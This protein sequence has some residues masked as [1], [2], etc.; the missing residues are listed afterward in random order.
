[1]ALNMP[2]SLLSNRQ[3]CA[4]ETERV[5]NLVKVEPHL[6]KAGAGATPK[7]SEAEVKGRILGLGVWM[8]NNGRPESSAKSTMNILKMLTKHTANF[9]DP[10]S[11]KAA[12]AKQAWKPSVKKRAVVAYTH[13]LEY[14]GL[15]WDPP[16]YKVPKSLPFVPLE[17]EVNQL[18]AALPK[19]TSTFVQTV[20]ETGARSGEVKNRLK[21]V[22]INRESRTI[23]IRMPEKGSNARVLDVSTNL[24]ERLEQLPKK[25]EVVFPGTMRVFYVSWGKQK[26]RLAAKLNNPRIA[27]ITLC[28]LRHLKGTMEYHRTRDIL[29]VKRLLGHQ[30]V[31]TT[32]IYID[33]DHAIFRT[34]N[35]QFTVRVAET[36]GEACQLIEVGF[37]YVTG[38]YMDG[39]KIFRKRK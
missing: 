21:W 27:N 4:L 15:T 1:M 8:L 19:K 31:N 35:D 2:S 20:K 17:E 9:L 38:D 10:E 16:R 24:I 33:L 36:V 6:Q 23:I 26:R 32:L 37:E 14:M 13:L 25:S 28:S 11:V 3:I 39:G 7:P 5:K 34:K 29:H 12:I 22:D 18:I 30:S